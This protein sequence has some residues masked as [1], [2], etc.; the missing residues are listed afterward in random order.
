MHLQSQPPTPL[1]RLEVMNEEMKKRL[2]TCPGGRGTWRAEGLL[3][4]QEDWRGGAVFPG[5]RRDSGWEAWI[6]GFPHVPL[7]GRRHACP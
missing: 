2:R 4:K 3:A 7:G 6:K 1:P 5:K